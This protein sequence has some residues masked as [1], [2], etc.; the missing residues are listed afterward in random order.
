MRVVSGWKA[1]VRGICVSTCCVVLAQAAPLM[2]LAEQ[3]QE[4]NIVVFRSEDTSSIGDSIYDDAN[5]A[6]IRQKADSIAM[7]W[8]KMEKRVA[9]DIEKGN[10]LDALGQ[11]SNYMGQLKSDM[12]LVSK[13]ACGGD[14]Y[15]RSDL[16]IGDEGGKNVAKFDYSTGKFSYKPIAAKAE[17]VIATVNDLYFYSID[18]TDAA[19]AL[20]ELQAT[21]DVFDEWYTMVEKAI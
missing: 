20:K 4:A 16:S 14:I 6:V 21:S 8:S 3:G 13:A 17:S 18:K 2:S 10:K 1:A 5:K 15:E 9:S 19:S 7:V 11:I 12:R